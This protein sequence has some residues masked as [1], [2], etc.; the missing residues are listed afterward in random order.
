MASR[1]LNV[2][3]TGD[4]RDLQRALGSAEKAAGQTEGKLAKFGANAKLALAGAAAAAGGL[5]VKG[6][7]D[8]VKAAQEAQKSQAALESQL[9]ALG[10]SYRDHAAEIDNVIQKT[11]QLSGL[12]DEDLQDSFTNLVR[13]TGNVSSALDAT[14]IAADIARAK[15]MDVARVGQLL[16]K[17]LDG[18]VT[19]LNRYGAG[20]EKGATVTQA[21]GQIQEK[22]KGQAQ[23]YGDTAAGAQDKFRVAVENLEEKLGQKL[24][25]VITSVAQAVTRFINQ[26]ESGT[27]AG[28]TF[29]TV[30]EALGNAAEVAFK[31]FSTQVRAI[32]A[33]EGALLGVYSVIADKVLWAL[34]HMSDAVGEVTG[35]ASKIPVVGKPF[36]GVSEAAHDAADKIKSVRNAIDSLHDKKVRI[37]VVTYFSNATKGG[38]GG[39]AGLNKGAKTSSVTANK[40]IKGNPGARLPDDIEAALALA[41]LSPDSGDDLAALGRAQKFWQTVLDVSKARGSNASVANA[42]SNLK[43]VLDQIDAVTTASASTATPANP[44]QALIDATNANT[45]A[46]NAAKEAADAAKEAADRQTQA[47]AEMRDEL[48]KSNAHADAVS[49]VSLNTAWKALA[50]V[51]SGQIAGYGGYMGKAQT[52]GAGSTYRL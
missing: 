18:N 15:H 29:K 34:Q 11:S 23:A 5:L 6:L 33:V 26:M 24:L 48:A 10:L 41:E 45:E 3:I 50:D 46:Q 7:A 28:G 35:I 51:V 9:K 12:D 19:A 40:G 47:V 44:N 37:D 52:A 49:R 39:F 38:G 1:N 27:G 2:T 43:G 14:G 30:V 32:A 16:G 20:V 22:F 25:P 4:S 8:S 17:V 13:V 21:L 31:V 36:K 42:A